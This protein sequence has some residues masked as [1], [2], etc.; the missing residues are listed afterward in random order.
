MSEWVKQVEGVVLVLCTVPSFEKGKAIARVL[1][2]S[3]LCACVNIVPQ[4]TSIYVWEGKICEDSEALLLVKTSRERVEEL[5]A[6]LG[7]L[8]PY[9]TPEIVAFDVDS[10]AD[11]YLSWVRR[12]TQG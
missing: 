4:L 2:E 11:S 12:A 10:G 8:H 3:R 1:V 7:K 6:E 5:A 9:E